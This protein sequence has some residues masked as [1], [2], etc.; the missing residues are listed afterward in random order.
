MRPKDEADKF[1]AYIRI[2]SCPS[3]LPRLNLSLPPAPCAADGK[4]SATSI[5]LS[6]CALDAT[7]KKTWNAV[8]EHIL[9]Y[10]GIDQTLAHGENKV[11][12]LLGKWISGR[13]PHARE[14][15]T[16]A[17][18][19][20][21]SPA[22]SLTTVALRGRALDM[23][24]TLNEYA[25]HHSERRQ[26]GRRQVEEEIYAKLGLDYIEPELRE[27]TGEIEA[28]ENHKMPKLVRLQDIRGDLQ[29]HTTASDGTQLH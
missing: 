1:A 19:C 25:P 3:P 22:R 26:G 20:C 24:W 7:S 14:R 4:P 16:S 28:A 11:S 6:P 2:R 18:R 21:I 12:V 17:P 9:K 13:C 27:M 8:A 5:F 23:G 10:P 29:M 15:K